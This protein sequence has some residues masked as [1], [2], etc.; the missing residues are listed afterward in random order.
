MRRVGVELL[1]AAAEIS[2]TFTSTRW[3]GSTRAGVAAC[4]AGTIAATAATAMKGAMRRRIEPQLIHR[5]A[6]TPDAS[7]SA[8]ATHI[9]PQ[10]LVV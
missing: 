7:K 4:T 2:S 3:A 8:S 6:P 9:A 10:R 5:R 1:D